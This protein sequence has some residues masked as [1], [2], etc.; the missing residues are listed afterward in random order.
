MPWPPSPP[1]TFCQLKVATSI[2]SQG[3]SCAK[4]AEVAS[5]MVRPSRSSAIQSPFGHAHARGGAVPGEDD[6]AR[7]IDRCEVGKLAVGR[8]EHGR[9]E[10]EL[11]DRRRSPS[12]RRSSPRR[13]G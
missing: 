7:R 2:L 6:V 10:L 9:V 13:A 8:L 5:A 12:P 11:L 3:R 1:S 4:A